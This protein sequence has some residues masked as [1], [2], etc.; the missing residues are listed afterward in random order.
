MN[1][2]FEGCLLARVEVGKIKD[3]LEKVLN[4]RMCDVAYSFLNCNDRLVF[5]ILCAVRQNIFKNCQVK[6]K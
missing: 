6:T 1:S 2:L 5:S 3:P 4:E